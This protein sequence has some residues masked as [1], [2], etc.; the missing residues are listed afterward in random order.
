MGATH[1]LVTKR[2]KVGDTPDRHW[3]LKSVGAHSCHPWV[4]HVRNRKKQTSLPF[5]G[6]QR[7]PGL[8]L[9]GSGRKGDIF[10][11]RVQ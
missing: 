11:G 10:R 1:L 7:G 6:A 8:G 2:E 4:L 5:G 9:S 3:V